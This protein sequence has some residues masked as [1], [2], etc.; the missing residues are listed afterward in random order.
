MQHSAVR[1]LH[2]KELFSREKSK[3]VYD[4]AVD[5]LRH[6]GM[7]CRDVLKEDDTNEE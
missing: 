6:G 4:D 7:L 2:N 5:A 3:K 1:L